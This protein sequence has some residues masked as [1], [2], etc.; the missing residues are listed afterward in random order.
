MVLMPEYSS[1]TAP[2]TP[3]SVERASVV[4]AELERILQSVAFRNAKRSQDFLRY[5]VTNALDGRTDCLKERSIG[6]EVFQRAVDYDTGEDSIVR[7][8]ASELRK[9]LAQFYHDAPDT[10]VQIELP[11]GSYVPEFRVRK[12]EAS[13]A[14]P[15]TVSRRTTVPLRLVTWVAVAIAL[16]AA[17]VWWFNRAQPVEPA[18]DAFWAPVCNSSSPVL[19]CVAHPV[20]Y[21]VGGRAREILERTPRAAEIP[22]DDVTRDAEHFIGFGDAFTLAQVTGFLRAK[23]KTVQLRMGNDVAFADL[24]NAPAVLIGAFTNQWTM[25]MTSNLRYVFDKKDGRSAIRDQMNPAQ[26]W[27]FPGVGAGSDYVLISR[28]FDSRSGNVVITAAGLGVV[29]T[30]MSGEFLSNPD[31]MEQLV[32][33]APADW[34][35]RNMQVVLSGEVIGRTVGPPKVVA[36]WYW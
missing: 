3:N 25:Q 14:S 11:A 8:K 7:V 19:L 34:R 20:V 31:Y 21:T 2:A 18:L 36:S 16:V 12:L 9:R 27:H 24:R 32:R 4:A 22:A 10:G 28:I 5:I 23:G 6:A 15:V 17:A 29:G 35:Q 26:A 13:P 30:Q 33:N 1:E